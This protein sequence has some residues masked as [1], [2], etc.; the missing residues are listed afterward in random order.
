M[1]L[2]RPVYRAWVIVGNRDLAQGIINLVIQAIS[3]STYGYPTLL[4]LR[5]LYLNPPP[6][7]HPTLLIAPSSLPSP[8]SLSSQFSAL[9][10]PKF[11]RY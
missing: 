5:C 3:F 9:P 10:K 1:Q 11:L 2:V 4:L 8:L 7:F 6:I